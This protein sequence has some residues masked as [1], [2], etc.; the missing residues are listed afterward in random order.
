MQ[1]NGLNLK[2]RLGRVKSDLNVKTLAIE[3]PELHLH[4]A[5]QALFADVFAEA[6]SSTALNTNSP[7]Q[8]FLVE[9]HSEAMINRLGELIGRGVVNADD[10]Q[11]LIFGDM[12]ENLTSSELS[13]A[14]FDEAGFLKNWP[15]GFFN[16]A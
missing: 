5:H 10:V 12:S 6:V 8:Y 13:V 9:T 1:N 2:N 15:Y 16:Y 14:G 11:V 4:P 3:Q 7:A